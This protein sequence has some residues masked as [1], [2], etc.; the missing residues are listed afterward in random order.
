MQ[1]SVRYIVQENWKE[2]NW[3]FPVNALAFWNAVISSAQ[4][5]EWLNY[6]RKGQMFVKNYEGPG[7]SWSSKKNDFVCQVHDLVQN[8]TRLSMCEI[9]VEV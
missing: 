7:L 6:F 1:N 3:N 8:D 9:T 5:S 4:I 2:D